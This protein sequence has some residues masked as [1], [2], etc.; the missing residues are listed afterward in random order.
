[1]TCRPGATQQPQASGRRPTWED[2][3]R[4][5]RHQTPLRPQPGGVAS[6]F[7]SSHQL[8]QIGPLIDERLAGEPIAER[9][10]REV[11]EGGSSRDMRDDEAPQWRRLADVTDN[12]QTDGVDPSDMLAKAFSVE[13]DLATEAQA[14][15]LTGNP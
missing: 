12:D 1:M 14:A 6:R 11:P 10:L 9:A 2:R 15:R 8:S 3:Q 13:H 4:V 5:R 7:E